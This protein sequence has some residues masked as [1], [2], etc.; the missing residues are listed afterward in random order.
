MLVDEVLCSSA[1]QVITT[2]QHENG[3]STLWPVHGVVQRQGVVP[4]VQAGLCQTCC[5]MVVGSLN[6]EWFPP[7][8]TEGMTGFCSAFV[9]WISRGSG[10]EGGKG[11]GVAIAWVW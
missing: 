4:Q 6:C 1:I 7:S 3:Y 10:L 9:Q 2:L 5:H 11:L 8:G